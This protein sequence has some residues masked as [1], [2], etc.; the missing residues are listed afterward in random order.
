MSGPAARSFFNIAD[1]WK[2]SVEEGRGLFG[3]PAISTY[4]K[5]KAGDVGTLS[6]DALTRVS[7]VLGMYKALNILYPNPNLANRWVKLP[8]SNVLF[9]GKTPVEFMT[10]DGGIDAMFK[11]RR[12]LDARRG[13]WN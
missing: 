13:G 7:L 8:N 1:L 6:Y 12:L 11:V 4:H 5:Y 2:L 3:W 10:A 9:G